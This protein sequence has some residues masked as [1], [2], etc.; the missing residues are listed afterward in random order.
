MSQDAALEIGAQG[1]LDMEGN[2][3]GE[4]VIPPGSREVGL[5]VVVDDFVQDGSFGATAL[6]D[7][8]AGSSGLEG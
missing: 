1:P 2:A 6:V 4:T 7:R 3:A 8:R 5:E